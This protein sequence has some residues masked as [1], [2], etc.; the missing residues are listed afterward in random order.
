MSALRRLPVLSIALTLGAAVTVALSLLALSGVF[1]PRMTV[2][3]AV[4][5]DACNNGPANDR[6]ERLSH[7]AAG[8]PIEYRPVG[9]VPL[10]FTTRTDSAGHY[11][12]DLPPRRY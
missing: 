9:W 6:C 10:S 8:V 7:P 11:P 12:L 1:G 2:A 5:F 3:G 4:Y